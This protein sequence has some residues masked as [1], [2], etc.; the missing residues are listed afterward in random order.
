MKAIPRYGYTYSTSPNVPTTASAVLQSRYQ[1]LVRP[2][3]IGGLDG[4]SRQ[5][6]FPCERHTII[7]HLDV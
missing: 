6:L 4:S 7:Q 1:K 5:H 2:V 3:T